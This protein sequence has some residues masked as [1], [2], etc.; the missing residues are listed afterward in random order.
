[1]RSHPIWGS[2]WR[3][4]THAD[5]DPHLRV[6]LT[7]PVCF[8]GISQA[9]RYVYRR[10]I[11]DG[12]LSQAFSVAP[13]RFTFNP[14]LHPPP[15][16]PSASCHSQPLPHSVSCPLGIPA[17]HRGTQPGGRSGSTAGHHAQ[18]VL[19]AGAGL[20]LLPA[21][22]AAEVGAQVPLTPSTGRLPGT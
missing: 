14:P 18:E 12:I 2:N 8:Q 13:V 9:A 20:R 10:L 16:P 6:S 3:T 19:P 15:P 1:M 17:G 7:R 21:P 22:G 4:Q 5:C 11:N